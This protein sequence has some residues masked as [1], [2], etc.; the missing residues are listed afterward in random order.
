MQN[1][2]VLNFIYSY[3]A[4]QIFDK[5]NFCQFTILNYWAEMVPIEAPK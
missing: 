2:S 4:S 3:T 5:S 1:I